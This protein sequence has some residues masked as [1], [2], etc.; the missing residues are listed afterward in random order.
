MKLHLTN[1]YGMAGD[2]TVILA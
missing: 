1:L 2:S